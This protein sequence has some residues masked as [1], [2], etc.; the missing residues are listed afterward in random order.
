M[1]HAFRVGERYRDTGSYRNPDDQFLRWIRGPL[2]SGI[3]NTGGIRDLGADRSDTPAALV[4][5][6]NDS[7][8]SQ[9][10]DPWEDT[11][12]V[13][14]GYITYWGDAKADNPYDESAQNQK[15]KAAFDD[16]A[17][18][19]RE[20]VPPVLVFRKPESGVVEFC[21]L[22][23]PD[24]FEVRAY[25]AEDGTQVPNYQFHFSILNTNAVP[26]TWLHDRAQQN[27]DSKA[28][29][30]WQQWIETGAVAQ[31]PTGEPLD[32]SGRIRRYE[33]SEITVSDAFRADILDRYDHA[34]TLTGIRED[35][36][37]DLAHILPRSQ[38]PDLAEHPENVLVLNS[39][40]HRA[41]DA[42]LFTIDSDYRIQASPS[43][44]PAHPFLRETILDREGEQL[45][46][47]PTVQIRS[48][49]LEE[50]NTGLSWL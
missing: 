35:E 26:V 13:N 8:I 25:R 36:L 10:D 42:A 49:F 22:C 32:S 33:T 43:F 37:L 38:H 41:F 5:V 48:S 46:F 7:G 17:A 12:A 15:I 44:D 50:L 24:H 30:V 2:D 27:D 11:L 9:H 34:C 31:W 20:N 16:A 40:H 39:L 6:S 1:Q 3:R 28:P 19:Q 47:P 4:L 45:S 21:G 14:A 29:D 23:V 18:G